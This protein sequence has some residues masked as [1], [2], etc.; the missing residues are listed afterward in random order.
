LSPHGIA[1][2]REQAPDLVVEWYANMDDVGDDLAFL[3]Q[4][5]ELSEA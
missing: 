2:L 3:R 4:A 5:Q 1:P